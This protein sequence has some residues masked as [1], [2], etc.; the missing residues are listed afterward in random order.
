MDHWKTAYESNQWDEVENWWRACDDVGQLL[1]LFRQLQ[2]DVP[3]V[4]IV[5]GTEEMEEFVHPDVAPEGW[6]GAAQILLLGELE[7]K[8]EGDPAP[9]LEEWQHLADQ[10]ASM[11]REYLG[12]KEPTTGHR[13]LSR[14]AHAEAVLDLLK[15]IDRD[16]KIMCAELDPDGTQ[17]D[18]RAWLKSVIAQ[19]ALAAFNAGAHARAAVGK[20]I[21][22]HAVRGKN[23]LASAQEGGRVRSE[24][25]KRTTIIVIAEMERLIGSGQSAKSA[26]RLAFQA[27][28]G[29]SPEGNRT[30]Y[31]RHI[32]KRKL[33]QPRH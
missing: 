16:T 30:A 29:A 4:K 10:T 11:M 26:A 28:Y 20:A 25:A 22:Q 15:G 19:T 17:P 33:G 1:A 7:A 13:L 32:E 2:R 21:E 23:T 31:K 5:N 14:A 12:A 18:D 9:E 24:G 3:R 6:R 27:G 8:I